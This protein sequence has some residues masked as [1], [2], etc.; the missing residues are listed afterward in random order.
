MS[1]RVLHVFDYY[2]SETMQWLEDLWISSDTDVEHH[3]ASLF[4]SHRRSKFPRIEHFGLSCEYPISIFSKLQ[5]RLKQSYYEDLILNYVKKKSIDIVHFHF[6]N[7]AIKFHELI[8][9]LQCKIFISLYGFDYEYLPYR[10]PITLDFYRRFARLGVHYIVEGTYSKKLLISYLISSDQIHVVQMYYNRNLNSSIK[11]WMLPCQLLQVATFS[12]KKGQLFLLEAISKSGV[13]NLLKVNFYGEQVEHS[14]FREL[15]LCI[16]KNKLMQ[17]S[18]N[19]K[20][21]TNDYQVVLS[22]THIGVNLS[23]KSKTNETEGGCPMFLKDAISCSKP[24]FTTKH[25]DIPDLA[26]GHFNSWIIDEN[27]LQ[28][29]AHTIKEIVSISSRDYSKLCHNAY[30]SALNKINSGWTRMN[31]IKAYRN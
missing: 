13:K 4:Y 2:L 20:L 23:M 9:K 14:Y 11:P 16:R 28:G 29:A 25:C 31:I 21:L 15:E 7:I 18:L 19:S 6:G 8:P 1:Y 12:E 22:N 26:I 27:D 3:L 5:T 24:V 30:Q 10:N 17:V